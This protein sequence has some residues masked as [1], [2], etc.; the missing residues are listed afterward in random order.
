MNDTTTR[1]LTDYDSELIA[2]ARV[3]TGLPAANPV[4]VRE[5]TGDEDSGIA[6]AVAFGRPQ[7]AVADLLRVIAHLTG[8]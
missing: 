8:E 7:A 1:T 4:A 3:V 6:Y 5:W 2:E